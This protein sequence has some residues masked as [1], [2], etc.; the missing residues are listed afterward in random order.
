MEASHNASLNAG[1]DEK[2]CSGRLLYEQSHE[3][4]LVELHDPDS[5]KPAKLD[6]EVPP[7]P[8]QPLSTMA[9]SGNYVQEYFLPGFGLSRHIVI[10]Q[11]Q[12]FLGPSARVRPY[13]YQSRDGYLIVGMPLTRVSSSSIGRFHCLTFP[14]V[15]SKI[16][17]A[18]LESTKGKKPFE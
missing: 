5:L 18:C 13:N 10:S 8:G 7:N 16:F 3:R 12:Y 11:L 9:Q 14:R 2:G 4:G 15:R 6:R 1:E 17:K